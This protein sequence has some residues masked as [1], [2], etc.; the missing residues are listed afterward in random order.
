LCRLEYLESCHWLAL[1]RLADERTR[2]ERELAALE[3]GS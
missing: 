2:L 1:A 3:E